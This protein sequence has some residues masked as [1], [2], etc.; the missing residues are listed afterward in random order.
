MRALNI[1]VVGLGKMGVLHSAIF[2]RLPDVRLCALAE[3]SGVVRSFASRFL[4]RVPI[5]AT[6]EEVLEKESPDAI[7]VTTPTFTHSCMAAGALRQRV[8]V[9][10]EKPLALT[11]RESLELA[12]LASGTASMVGFQKRF[13]ETFA[14]ARELIA[15][16]EIGSV[17]KIEAYAFIDD[18][19]RRGKGW[20]FD[21]SKGGGALADVGIHALDLLGWFFPDVKIISASHESPVSESVDDA[22]TALFE[23]AGAQGT[24]EVSWC[25]KGFRLLEL[26]IAVTGDKSSLLATDS[27]LVLE[28]SSGK[29][30]LYRAQLEKPVGYLLGFPEFYR[31]DSAFAEAVAAGKESPVPFS[32]GLEASRL[33]DEIKAVSVKRG[34]AY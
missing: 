12:K 28:S 29:K 1:G 5:Y 21:R 34:A 31:E 10:C 6:C 13:V 25:R 22:A 8:P 26:G 9:F 23:A 24:L 15:Q 18:V 32:A 11:Y 4:K 19:V 17:Q 20:R 2:S 30:V 27:K 14:K 3:N 7:V 16:G 33:A